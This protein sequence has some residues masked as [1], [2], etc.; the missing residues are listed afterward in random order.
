MT[1]V[2]FKQHVSTTVGMIRTNIS[3]R[4]R[5]GHQ[6]PLNPRKIRSAS[7][8]VFFNFLQHMLE[9]TCVHHVVVDIFRDLNSQPYPFANLGREPVIV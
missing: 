2:S 8:R 9:K 5:L 1:N 3:F 7:T 4:G 6:K